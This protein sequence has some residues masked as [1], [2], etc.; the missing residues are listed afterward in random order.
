VF[1]VASKIFWFV[2]APTNLLIMVTA[3]GV[4]FSFSR[5]KPRRWARSLAIV[6]ALALVIAGFSPLGALLLRPLEDR[7]PQPSLAGLDPS[8]IIVLGG[9]VD[10]EISK[11]RGEVHLIEGAERLTAGVE[12][13]SRFPKA[14]LVY[15]GGSGRL[16]S[17]GASEAEQARRLWIDLNIPA[18]R[19]LIE[20]RSRNTYENAV[21]TRDLLKPVPGETFVLV[22]SAYHMPRSVGLFRKAGFAVVPVPVDY[23]TAGTLQDLVPKRL[24]DE[25]LALVDLSLREWIGLAAYYATG[26]IDQLLPGP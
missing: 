17:S 12:L 16:L 3:V 23:R 22:T 1:F 15:T 20:D 4:L 2:A 9:P 7:F 11:A 10:E 8:G 14:R 21:F 24:A 18:A 26:K 19:I 5:G 25:G 13:A 6:G